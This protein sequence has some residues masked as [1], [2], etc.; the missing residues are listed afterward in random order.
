MIELKCK[1]LSE[2]ATIPTKNN[3]SDAGWDIYASKNVVLSPMST[4]KVST[5]I[6]VVFP[7]TVWG[8]IEG[9]SGLAS[10]GVFP[11]G[12]IIDQSYTGHVSVVLVNLNNEG[13]SI[14][15]GDRIAQLVLRHQIDS[16]FTEVNELPVTNRGGNGF[17]SSGK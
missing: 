13:Y 10:K 6:A 11:T 4:T 12:G 15:K 17:G 16:E 14:C 8:Q 5:D 2:D 9:R 3:V 7:D 1:K